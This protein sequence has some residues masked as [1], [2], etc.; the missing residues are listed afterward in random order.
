M[1]VQR[2]PFSMHHPFPDMLSSQQYQP[3]GQNW[4]DRQ[5]DV[6]TLA[7]TPQGFVNIMHCMKNGSHGLGSTSA[8]G[9]HAGP[10][11]QAHRL[12]ALPMPQ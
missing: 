3:S 11:A 2:H 12:G 10:G 8:Q 4:S 6:Q 7:S 9:R 5:S 1:S